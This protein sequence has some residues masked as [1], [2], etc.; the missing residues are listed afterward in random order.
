MPPYNNFN[1]KKMKNDNSGFC[2]MHLGWLT[3]GGQKPTF[4][5][6]TCALD[7]AVGKKAPIPVTPSLRTHKAP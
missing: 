7:K 1:D 4:T 3:V 6:Y 2:L 5:Q